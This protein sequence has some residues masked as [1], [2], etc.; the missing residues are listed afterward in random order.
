MRP[1]CIALFFVSHAIDLKLIRFA[2]TLSEFLKTLTSRYFPPNNSVLLLYRLF[3][4]VSI[5]LFSIILIDNVQKA[6]NCVNI[7]SS[8]TFASLRF[9]NSDFRYMSFI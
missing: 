9:V 8:Q 5:V 2:A 4:K 3:W 1:L 7:P 6:T